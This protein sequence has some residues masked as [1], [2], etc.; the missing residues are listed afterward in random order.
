M[1]KKCSKIY[2]LKV[3]K[4]I[5]Y[6]ALD[7]KQGTFLISIQNRQHEYSIEIRHS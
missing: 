6:N 5:L 7:I 1:K 2:K 4:T 3:I